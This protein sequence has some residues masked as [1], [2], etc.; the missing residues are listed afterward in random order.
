ML[1]PLLNTAEMKEF[2]RTFLLSTVQ[3]NCLVEPR[4]DVPAGRLAVD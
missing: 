1:S 3:H 4:L 2:L